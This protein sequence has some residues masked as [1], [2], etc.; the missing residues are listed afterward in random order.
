MTTKEALIFAARSYAVLFR[1]SQRDESS[2]SESP[3]D[4]SFAMPLI[5][6]RPRR[7]SQ[8][9]F[10]ISVSESKRA[11]VCRS[12]SCKYSVGKSEIRSR[13][14]AFSFS[15]SPKHFPS[16]PFLRYLLYGEWKLSGHVR[17][18]VRWILHSLFVDID[19]LYEYTYYSVEGK[20]KW[21]GSRYQWSLIELFSISIIYLNSVYCMFLRYTKLFSK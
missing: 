18:L 19:A 6:L 16:R 5:N 7:A 3:S 21:T 2:A 20:N 15:V 10:A 11:P 4:S 1:F 8:T 12:Y 9:R 14:A 13:Q 17:D